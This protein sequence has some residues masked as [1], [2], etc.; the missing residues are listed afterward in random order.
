MADHF[1]NLV[2]DSRPGCAAGAESITA[3]ECCVNRDGMIDQNRVIQTEGSPANLI[4]GTLHSFG[5]LARET[6]SRCHF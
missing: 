2:L 1:Q 6:D 4:G 3:I 5:V